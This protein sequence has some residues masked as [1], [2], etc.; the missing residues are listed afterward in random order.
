MVNHGIPCIWS[1]TILTY[2]LFI[3]LFLKKWHVHTVVFKLE[4]VLWLAVRLSEPAAGFR[5]ACLA[6]PAIINTRPPVAHTDAAA[7]LA[8]ANATGPFE[9]RTCPLKTPSGSKAHKVAACVCPLPMRQTS[10]RA[11]PANIP[12]R[13]G[14][15]NLPPALFMSPL[16]SGVRG[17]EEEERGR[18]RSRQRGG[19]WDWVSDYHPSVWI[20]YGFLL[21][22]CCFFVHSGEVN[23]LCLV[24]AHIPRR[25][26]CF[27]RS[28][29]RK[30]KNTHDFF[31]FFFNIPPPAF[32][33]LLCL[34]KNLQSAAD[35]PEDES[36]LGSALLIRLRARGHVLNPSTSPASA[37]VL[38]GLK[39][40]GVA[41][42]RYITNGIKSAI[43]HLAGN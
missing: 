39:K 33:P 28:H 13:C 11:F 25:L 26:F 29:G 38:Q 41:Y 12:Y 27:V 36:A 40:P 2:C 9:S 3:Y 14:R 1:I 5:D 32:V 16:S 43:T 20:H 22:V 35:K 18:G 7:E 4:I 19:L 23:E 37:A 24:T 17:E 6:P 34:W 42:T 15:C 30:K 8:A 10:S 21:F 31:F